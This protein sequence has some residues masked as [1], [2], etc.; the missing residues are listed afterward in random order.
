MS[1]TYHNFDRSHLRT[2]L[3]EKAEDFQVVLEQARRNPGRL[4]TLMQLAIDYAGCLAAADP[5]DEALPRV[6]RIGGQAAAAVFTLACTP[7]DESVTVQLGDGPPASYRRDKPLPSTDPG[8][9]LTGFYLAAIV[10]DQSCKDLLCAVPADRIRSSQSRNSLYLVPFVEALRALHLGSHDAL[11]NAV[12]AQTLLAQGA[13]ALG[14]GDAGLDLDGPTI[15]LSRFLAEDDY[16]G[17]Q[18]T[19]ENAL[20]LHRAH[21]GQDRARRDLPAGVLP[22]G[23]L[24]MCCLAHDRGVVI[25]VVSDYLPPKLVERTAAE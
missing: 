2:L 14:S 5:D 4:S 11:Q 16:N 23:P 1:V 3:P 9:W 6:L 19:L 12:A 22:L 13:S 21:W 8:R 7:T 17:F 24:A 25:T 18:A 15:D 20:E 10:R